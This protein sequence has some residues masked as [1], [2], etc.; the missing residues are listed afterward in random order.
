LF[1]FYEY[2]NKDRKGTKL[3]TVHHRDKVILSVKEMDNMLTQK[4]RNQE[5][6]GLSK[7]GKL[8][9]FFI[10]VKCGV[11]SKTNSIFHPRI[12][13]F[14]PLG[15]KFDCT[16]SVNFSCAQTENKLLDLSAPLQADDKKLMYCNASTQSD[17]AMLF[18]N[19]TAGSMDCIV[20][21]SSNRSCMFD[22]C[23]HCVTCLVCCQ[24]LFSCPVCRRKINKIKLVY[25]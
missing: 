20:C 23:G 3:E 10:M 22:P 16:N 14:K 6:P 5:S 7:Q 19:S 2:I 12:Q 1:L 8:K 15:K 13:N 25:F 24:F 18:L 17:E 4:Y 21:F 11:I 9:K